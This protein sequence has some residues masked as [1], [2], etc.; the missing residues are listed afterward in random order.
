[1]ADPLCMSTG[2]SCMIEA[3]ALGLVFVHVQN[4]FLGRRGSQEDDVHC[5][6]ARRR[7]DNGMEYR[8]LDCTFDIS[9][10]KCAF[11]S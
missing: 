9:S 4:R 7:K 10:N 1:M 6:I 5:R 2:M 3:L 8:L 11:Y